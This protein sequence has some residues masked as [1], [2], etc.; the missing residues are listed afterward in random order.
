MQQIYEEAAKLSLD[1]DGPCYNIVLLNLQVKR[2]SPEHAMLEP[3]GVGQVREALFRYFM[4]F[5]EYLIFQWNISLYCIL[6]KGEA[7]QMERLR[8]QCVENIEKSVCRRHFQWSGMRQWES[9]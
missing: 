8:G 6:I 7:D 3:E 1:L 2:Q 5:P 9:L 4:R